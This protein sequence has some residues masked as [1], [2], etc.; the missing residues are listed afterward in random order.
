[1]TLEA[2]LATSKFYIENIS[3]DEQELAFYTGFPNYSCFNGRSR[4]LSSLNEFFLRLRL[5]LFER[6]LAKC[7]DVS[8]STVC[9]IC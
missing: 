4:I 9:R 8:R 7:F 6:D 1:M 2:K 3:T 5:G